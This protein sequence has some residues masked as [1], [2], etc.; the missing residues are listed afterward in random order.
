M[1]RR[2]PR[3]TLF[4]YTT[5]FR[6]L[7]RIAGSPPKIAAKLENFL[8]LP[9][10]PAVRAAVLRV[11]EGQPT[12]TGEIS[13]LNFLLGELFARAALG[14][15]RRFRVPPQQIDLIGSH[16]QTIYH[17]GHPG[18]FPSSPPPLPQRRNRQRNAAASATLRGPE[19]VA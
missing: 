4:P 12:T 14:A 9:F 10:P 16:G 13:Q 6:S 11:A 7:V 19:R 15:C 1:I 3:S 8:T 17:Q 2:P 5:L 18:P